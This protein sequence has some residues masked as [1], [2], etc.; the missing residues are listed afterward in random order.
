MQNYFKS[1]F[2]QNFAKILSGF[3]G[4]RTVFPYVIIL[5]HNKNGNT[6][7]VEILLQKG[8]T[9]VNATDDNGRT[10]LY[11]VAKH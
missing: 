3:I 1:V 11:L 10:P 5:G 6:N 4:F 2:I 9:N 8:K 7:M